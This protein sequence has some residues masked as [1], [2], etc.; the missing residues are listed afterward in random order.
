MMDIKGPLFQWFINSAWL[1]G[2]S[3]SGS[4]VKSKVMSNQ[5]SADELHK[6]IIRKFEISKVYPSF[7]DSI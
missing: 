3:A 7:K 2:K 4:G 6:Q 5:E 1:T